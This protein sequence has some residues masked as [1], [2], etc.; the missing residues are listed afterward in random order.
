VTAAQTQASY[1]FLA[2]I[3][4]FGLVVLPVLIRRRAGRT[5]FHLGRPTLRR[6]WGHAWVAFATAG[7]VFWGT[8]LLLWLLHVT[9]DPHESPL[10]DALGVVSVGGPAFAGVTFLQG[11][12]RITEQGLVS[13]L[14]IVYWEEL[15]SYTW[16]DARDAERK[17][18]LIVSFT[19]TQGVCAGRELSW[20]LPQRHKRAI[21][22]LLRQYVGPMRAA[23]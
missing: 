18:A 9:H 4:L 13:F 5:L 11:C 8:R 7:L 20:S 12:W 22:Q 15:A 17:G 21:L 3:V 16:T 14:H 23:R 10:L 2:V 6:S 19:R 1:L